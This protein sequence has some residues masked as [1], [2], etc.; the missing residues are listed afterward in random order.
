MAILYD[1]GIRLVALT[2][3]AFIG[4]VV[5][6]YIKM[7]MLRPKLP[8]GPFPLPIIGNMH[9]LKS[10]KPWLQ[11]DKWSQE[12]GEG[13]LTIWIGRFPI[14]ICND[15][16]SASELMEKRSHMYSSRPRYVI[17]GDITGQQHC[18]QVFMPH[19]DHWRLQRKIMH[20]AVG[21]QALKPYKSFQEDEGKILMRELLDSPKDFALYF[22]RYACSLVSILGYGRRIDSKDDYMLRFAV[23]MMDGITMM[24]VPGLYWLE[25]IP[26]LQYLPS[27]IYAL[28]NRLR[29]RSQAV[30]KYWWGLVSEGAQARENNFAKTLVRSKEEQGLTEL[31]IAEMIANTIGGGLDTTSSTLH[32]LV[33]GLCVFPEAQKKAH[34]EL[35]RVVG[36]D[37]S[38]TW[39]DLDQ[40]PYCA[41]VLKEAMRWRSVTAMGGFAHCPERDDEYR[42]YHFPAGIAVFGNL[43]GI[44]RNP[45]D[46]PEPDVFNP[47]R[48]L[49]ENQRQYPNSRGH[50]AFG[51]GRRSCSGQLFAE[52]GLAMTVARMLWCY[53][54]EPG[55]DEFGNPVKLDIW[56]FTDNENTQPRPFPARFL[57]RSETIRDIIVQQAQE[58]RVRLQVYES[59]AKTKFS[60]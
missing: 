48:Y 13:L 21:S 15:A 36:Q 7:L 35:D 34:E 38:P 46:F 4:A 19:N 27:W 32:T 12:N 54:F 43:W 5:Y 49:K 2:S 25:A 23:S 59:E 6:S 8:P 52:Q 41:A 28:P 56:N 11:F 53:N 37:R 60:L 16:W 39:D 1:L 58:A 33:L 55:L 14:I 9:L 29:K 20:T 47:D 18:N 3:V 57:P 45:K 24:Q 50:N 51:W 42:G 17:F 31:D 44:H 10:S 40:L 22:E 26:E 30:A